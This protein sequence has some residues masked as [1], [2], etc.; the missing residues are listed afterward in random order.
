M[1]NGR[2]TGPRSLGEEPSGW[3]FVRPQRTESGVAG[4]RPLKPDKQKSSG[5][6]GKAGEIKGGQLSFPISLLLVAG[7]P[8]GEPVAW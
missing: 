7:K 1:E 2:F 4:F 3:S 8:I 5:T 6:S